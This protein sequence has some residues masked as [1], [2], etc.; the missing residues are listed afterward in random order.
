MKRISTIFFILLFTGIVACIASVITTKYIYHQPAALFGYRIVKIL[1][2][3][4]SPDIPENSYILVKNIQGADVKEGDVVVHIPAYGDYAGLPMTHKCIRGPELETEGVAAGQTCILTQGT[5]AGAPVDPPVPIAN[6]QSVYIKS[7]AKAGGFFDF[8]TSIWGIVVLIAVPSL[9]VIVMQ[10]IRMV[11]AVFAKPD[12]EA[13]KAEAERIERE[14]Q[15]EALAEMMRESGE[16]ATAAKGTSNVGELGDVMAF[17]AREKA[18]SASS[19]NPSTPAA[20]TDEMSSVMAFI[21]REKA[22]LN[23]DD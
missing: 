21:A 9:I 16:G 12:E 2:D 3:S 23:K 13:V 6:V 5:K 10:V 4:M 7:I 8:L 18:K 11:R 17:I 14:R 20:P 1:T 15:G 19:D 22:K